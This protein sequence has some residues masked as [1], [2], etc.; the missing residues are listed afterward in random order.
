MCRFKCEGSYGFHM[1]EK[2]CRFLTHFKRFHTLS[3]AFIRF[4]MLSY[5]YVCL[6]TLAYAYIHLHMLSYAFIVLLYTFTCFYMHKTKSVTTTTRRPRV[7]RLPA[8]PAEAGKNHT[9]SIFLVARPAGLVNIASSV[10][11]TLPFLHLIEEVF[12]FSGVF[13]W[14]GVV[15]VQQVLL[16]VVVKN[17]RET[18]PVTNSFLFCW[19][20]TIEDRCK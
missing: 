8:L 17:C 19:L 13:F 12:D 7:T 18:G 1:L 14:N 2:V 11:F 3:N 4:Y 5:A 10:I 6:H 9:N 20:F 15:R 16:I